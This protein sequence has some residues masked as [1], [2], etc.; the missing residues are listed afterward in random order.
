[1]KQPSNFCC[2]WMYMFVFYLAFLWHF[3][4]DLH[5]FY[6]ILRVIF[7]KFFIPFFYSYKLS[8][9]MVCFVRIL[10]KNIHIWQTL[11]LCVWLFKRTFIYNKEEIYFYWPIFVFVFLSTYPAHLHWAKDK[12][13]REGKSKNYCRCNSFMTFFV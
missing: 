9:C 13:D 5:K 7:G 1:M 12:K 2:V 11:N 8:N 10:S 4:M 3:L 6:D